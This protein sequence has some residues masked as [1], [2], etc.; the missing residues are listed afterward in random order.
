MENENY[1]KH[2]RKMYGV[3]LSKNFVDK[4]IKENNNIIKDFIK[5]VS[6]G[7]ISLIV[8]TSLTIF[9]IDFIGWSATKF[10]IIW[11]VPLWILR[12]TILKMFRFNKK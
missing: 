12:F 10:L 9:F 5:F 2:L 1:L 11:S 4:Q 7:A 3:R 8:G 6:S